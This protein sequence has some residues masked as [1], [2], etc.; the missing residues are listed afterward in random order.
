V[1][2]SRVL[3]TV[4]L[5]AAVGTVAALVPSGVGAQRSSTEMKLLKMNVPGKVERVVWSVQRSQ[6]SVQ[7]WGP[8]FRI[9]EEDP[10]NE[11]RAHEGLF[12]RTQV[13]LLKSDGTAIPQT[14]KPE[15]GGVG[16]NSAGNRVVASY[17]P[18]SARTTAISVVVSVD[19]QF[20][21]EPLTFR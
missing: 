20:L 16:N 4:A 15:T 18:A 9:T 1:E 8:S 10:T 5:V 11:I 19:D 21:V 2:M 17:F 7:I 3:C 13:W 14:R 12:P 6:C